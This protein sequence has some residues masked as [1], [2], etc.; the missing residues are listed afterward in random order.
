MVEL[1]YRYIKKIVTI[2][3]FLRMW[4]SVRLLRNYQLRGTETSAAPRTLIFQKPLKKRVVTVLQNFR[5]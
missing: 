3:L 2:H 1:G 4:N 5:K